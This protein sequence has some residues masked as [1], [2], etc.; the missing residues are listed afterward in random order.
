[1]VIK[2]IFKQEFLFGWWNF[3]LVGVGFFL[4]LIQKE[5]F[6]LKWSV[7][8]SYYTYTIVSK[9]MSNVDLQCWLKLGSVSGAGALRAYEHHRLRSMNITD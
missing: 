1:M 3:Y 7:P 8:H 9:K 4:N 2:W 6:K 5:T